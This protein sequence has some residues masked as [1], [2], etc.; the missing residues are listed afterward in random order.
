MLSKSVRPHNESISGISLFK[1]IRMK[2][3]LGSEEEEG[4]GEGRAVDV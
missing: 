2:R 3:N 4:K 1:V